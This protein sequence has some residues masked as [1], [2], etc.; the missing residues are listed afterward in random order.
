MDKRIQ[1]WLSIDV[2]MVVV[3]L[4]IILTWFGIAY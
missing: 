2:L 3:S 1:F 4:A